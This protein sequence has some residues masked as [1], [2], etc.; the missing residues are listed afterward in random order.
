MEY[1]VRAVIIDKEQ[2][3]TIERVLSDRTFWV[4]PG[5]GAEKEDSN[6]VQALQRECLEEINAKIEVGKFIWRRNFKGYIELFY[7]AKIISDRVGKG[8]GPEYTQPDKYSGTHEPKWIKIEQLKNILFYP[9]KLK[10]MILHAY[11]ESKNGTKWENID[12]GSLPR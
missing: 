5:G 12:W 11:E 2:I 8:N 7:L 4:T 1:R 6:P 9:E 3:L 10:E